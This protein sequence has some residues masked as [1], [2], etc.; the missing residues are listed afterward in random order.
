MAHSKEEQDLSGEGVAPPSQ[1]YSFHRRVEVEELLSHDDARL[2]DKHA[3]CS[4]LDVSR[5]SPVGNPFATEWAKPELVLRAYDD[6]LSI[7][8]WLGLQGC[9]AR[10]EG[11][12][13]SIAKRHGLQLSK[14]TGFSV[15]AAWD[16]ISRLAEACGPLRVVGCAGSAAQS[17]EAGRR[18]ADCAYGAVMWLKE[19]RKMGSSVPVGMAGAA[20]SWPLWDIFAKWPRQVAAELAEFKWPLTSGQEV[21]ALL[22]KTNAAPKTLVAFE[23]TGAVRDAYA[24]HWK[25]TKVAL[26][27]DIR[28]TLT[29]GPHAKMDV[30]EVI[31]MARWEEAYLH[32]PCTHQVLSDTRAAK[33]KMLDGR[34]YWGVAL[35]IRSWCVKADRVLLEQPPTII[36]DFYLSPTQVVRPCDVGDKDGKQFHL[37]E[38]G[39]RLPLPRNPAAI[40]TSGHKRLRDF[41]DADARDRWRSSWARFP[42]G[43][44]QLLWQLWRRGPHQPGTWTM[45]RK[46]SGLLAPGMT[47]VCLYRPTMHHPMPD[48]PTP[49]TGPIS[50]CEVEAMGGAFRASFQPHGAGEAWRATPHIMVRHPLTSRE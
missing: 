19:R 44:V 49:T 18:P 3:A 6:L 39:S 17:N 23:F 33:C 8:L 5:R 11:L 28:D 29:P 27:V 37:Y 47:Q 13:L 10:A 15:S 26:S 30:R 2:L 48:Q 46:L 40:G 1:L 7:T 24:R 22:D 12:P 38:R 41:E 25:Y 21:A 45:Q 43:C 16:Y 42:Q 14:A 20:G 35:F 32:P 50:Q 9:T 36:P 31:D 4:V 34:A